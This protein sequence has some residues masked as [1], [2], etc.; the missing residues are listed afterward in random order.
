M[1]LL[2]DS[3][4]R[5]AAYCLHR[6]V[7][8]YS[9][10]PLL[11]M[12]GLVF[13]LAYFFWEDALDAVRGLL[14]SWELAQSV[15]E[16]LASMGLQGFKAVVAPL[17]V[18]F[19]ATPL[20]VLLTLLAVTALMTPAMLRLVAERRFPALERRH[21]GSYVSSIVGGLVASLVALVALVVSVPFWFIPPLVLVLPPL[22]WGWMTYRVMSYDVL[23][24]HAT[25]LERRTLIRR[26]RLPLFG[27]GVVSG[28]LG[29][30]PS[31][32]W[33]SGAGFLIIAPLLIPVA[34]WIYTLVFAFSA[35]W[36]SHYALAALEAMRV[37]LDTV[38]AP[39]FYPEA[40]GSI[41]ADASSRPLSL[42]LREP[43]S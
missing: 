29:A 14:D 12:A 2:F 33:A 16:W 41:G 17:V 24:E 39:P 11:L 27:M 30:A 37:E 20:V 6:R 31:V 3:F 10:A 5:A 22:I 4:W 40:G 43:S 8:L 21:G 35:L 36:F 42:P 25:R 15:N 38:P 32:V 23:A 26:H 18:V 1:K 13:G 7:I 34:I 9:L 28:L 19:L